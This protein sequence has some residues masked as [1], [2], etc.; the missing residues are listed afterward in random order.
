MD[1]IDRYIS[2][3][4][5]R[6]PNANRDDICREL[7]SALDD[8]L[9]ARSFGDPSETDIVAVLD[10]FGSP[11]A[12]AASY[13]GDKYLIG[14]ELYPQFVKTLKIVAAILAGLVVLGSAVSLLSTSLGFE[15]FTT[16][17]AGVV[18]GLLDSFVSAVG[19]VVI[20][21]ALLERLDLRIDLGDKKKAWNPLA[22]PA[23]RDVDLVGRFDSIAGVV[24][25]AIVLFLMN[26]FKDRIGLQVKAESKG[27]S[28]GI[29]GEPEGEL[30][31]NDVF[32]D[33]LPGLN[34]SLILPMALSAW[35]FWY[36]RWNL[37]TR[38]LKIA[39]DIFG[40]WVFYLLCQGF[41]SIH[42]D[43]LEVGIPQLI[44]SLFV[45]V[46]ELAP[47]GVALAV[48]IGAGSH[49]YKAFRSSR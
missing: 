45:R 24:F 28:I 19:I 38:L 9:E 27:F 30:L 39:F 1:L 21:F 36:G 34:A 41:L 47:Y 44:V 43:L 17:V 2:E 14:P 23:V 7:R 6:L 10:E 11:Q 35:L 33:L 25:P 4:G 3:V 32:L 22:L 46:A 26:H 8:A 40:V 48:L 5:R 31:F 49:L 42:S 29:I 16:R 12:V 20:I 15:A 18:S 13:S 37:P